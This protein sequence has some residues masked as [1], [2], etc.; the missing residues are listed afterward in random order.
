[1][2]TISCCIFFNSYYYWFNILILQLCQLDLLES[3]SDELLRA[4]CVKGGQVVLIRRHIQQFKES[5]QIQVLLI[6]LNIC[7]STYYI[8]SIYL[9]IYWHHHMPYLHITQTT[10]TKSNIANMSTQFFIILGALWNKTI[11]NSG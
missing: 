8:L 2:L 9:S 10:R 1:M 11:K 7:I 5:S 6:Y 4:C 3:T